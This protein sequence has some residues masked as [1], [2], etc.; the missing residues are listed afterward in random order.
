[1]NLRKLKYFGNLIK[2]RLYLK[3][4]IYFESTKTQPSLFYRK[5]L[6]VDLSNQQELN[7]L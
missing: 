2:N 7:N 1:M 3:N 6:E 5:W 4:K